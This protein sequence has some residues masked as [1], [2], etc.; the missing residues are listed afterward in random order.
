MQAKQ[1]L[2]HLGGGQR[3]I[4]SEDMVGLLTACAKADDRPTTES[5]LLLLDQARAKDATGFNRILKAMSKIHPESSSS[6]SLLM[7]RALHLLEVM[8]RQQLAPDIV[9]FNS[10]IGICARLNNFQQA[11]AVYDWIQ[12]RRLQPSI[13]T[14]NSLINVCARQGNASRALE[15]YAALKAD[16]SLKPNVI[17]LNSLLNA[18]MKAGRTEKVFE[19]FKEM[20]SSSEEV[21]PDVI[22][23]TTLIDAHL[24][25]GNEQQALRVVQTMR[26]HD[27]SP[28]RATFLA[29]LDYYAIQ[30]EDLT[31]ALACYEA[32][33]RSGIPLN[34]RI[35]NILIN[36]CLKRGAFDQMF[37]VAE[38]LDKEK[39][40][41]NAVTYNTVLTNCAESND[42]TT[43]MALLE[44][45]KE[46]KKQEEKKEKEEERIVPHLGVFTLLVNACK[47][48]KDAQTA[49][50]LLEWMKQNDI[51]PDTIV[52]NAVM[53]TCAQNRDTGNVLRL[54]KE[55]QQSG[56]K[57]SSGSFNALV[58][59]HVAAGEMECAE[60]L[61]E[62]MKG[63]KEEEA[64]RPG[65]D[66]YNCL[67]RGYAQ[68]GGQQQKAKRVLEQM[69]KEGIHENEATLHLKAKLGIK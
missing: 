14:F 15:L 65:V 30:K 31:K 66:I 32:M 50:N 22:T 45:M 29:F 18:C 57:L 55:M 36:I 19:L 51:Q 20:V 37:D 53:H 54:W 68:K 41:P 43:A 38:A 59:A 47:R 61:V 69:K 12:E 8:K 1:L 17:T 11:F 40:A 7:E 16:R 48:N 33:K 63:N 52:Y 9:T 26:L 5:A 27:V 24:K 13:V 60:T 21:R 62:S 28:D 42:T 2:A 23:Y 39:I 6:S 58:S 44:W 64:I 3:E 67:L 56:L 10:L 34:V 46:K 49:L 4:D 35:A 25:T